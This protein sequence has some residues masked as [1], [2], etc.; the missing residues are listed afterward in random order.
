MGLFFG[1]S[2]YINEIEQLKEEN[3]K[4]ALQASY[5]KN[6]LSECGADD[7]FLLK[8]KIANLTVELS[9]IENKRNN[10]YNEL[11]DYESKCEKLSKA[12][13]TQENK[14][15]RSKDLVKA[16]NYTIENFLLYEP[17][18]DRIK[19]DSEKMTALE[20]LSPTV[21][22]KLNSMNIPDL[23][24]AYRNNEHQI[25]QVLDQYSSRYT[26]KANKAIY[27]L[28]VIALMSELQN[29]LYNLKYEKLDTAINQVKS[30]ANK[31]LEIAGSGNQTIVS[32]LTKF[33]G[34]IEYLFINA[35]KIEYNYY[36]KKEQS[37]QEQ[38]EIKAQMRQEAAERKALLEE[39]KRIEAEEAKYHS[40][41][42]R[43]N[44]QAKTASNE[45]LAVIN[46]RILEVTSQLSSVALKK[47]KIASLAKGKAG[48][49]YVIS[50]MGSFGP[51]MF[52]IGMTR[53][54]DPQ[55]RVNELGDAS[56]PFKFDVHCMIFSEDAVD[57]EA[58]IHNMLNKKRVNKVNL[59]KEFFYTTIDEL[60]STVHSIDPTA[61]FNTTM[62]A[63][64]YNQSQS[65]DEPYTSEGPDVND[66]D[67]NDSDILTS[68]EN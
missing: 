7:Y 24:K 46:S 63:E 64:E 55:D 4:L 2:K 39:Q 47:E 32:T 26:T 40:E 6:R 65:S 33:I 66:D 10:S 37:R 52:K 25:N 9:D 53:R 62:L 43:L 54:S 21:M 36:V 49:V 13:K 31:Y 44:E 38:L 42:E 68:E 16:I 3:Q 56:V 20:E 29:I 28:M 50:N 30:V 45:E 17:A 51:N 8:N 27:D 60:E 61:E 12:E 41:I 15:T 18:Q 14:I 34:E 1:K 22:L 48:S 58:K 67:E 57:L 11:M 35:V 19:F 23:K 59:R 5:L